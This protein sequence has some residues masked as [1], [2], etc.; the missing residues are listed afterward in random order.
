MIDLKNKFSPLTLFFLKIIAVYAV[1][2]IVYDL[3]ILPDARLDKWLS[4]SG[5]NLAAIGLSF[6]GWD[7]EWSGRILSCVG[8][9][10]VEIQ[11]GCNGFDSLGLYSGFIIAYPGDMKKRIA[12]L[13]G[14]I[15]LIYFA[16][17]FRIAFFTLSNVYF[18]E[19]WNPI[20]DYSAYAFFYP[21]VL[22]LWYLWTIE[23]GDTK[24]AT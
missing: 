8:S 15:A 10:G 23:N 4:E 7:I 18:P 21:I 20:H 3:L 9:R 11:N 12:F 24:F 16:N 6:L 5:V 19:Y 13:L 14:G 1:W 2:H 17:V 22:I